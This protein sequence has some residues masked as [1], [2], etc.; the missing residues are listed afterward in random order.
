MERK[1]TFARQALE[2][3]EEARSQVGRLQRTVKML[4]SRCTGMVRNHDNP[5]GS[6]CHS[7]HQDL[8]DALAD[9]QSLLEQKQQ[10][11]AELEQKLERWIDRIPRPRWRMVLRFHYIDAL[12]LSETALE[13]T[14]AT[15]RE[16]TKDQVY[17][18]H[19]NALEA[20]DQIWP[21][22]KH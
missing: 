9:Q 12:P 3:L 7:T 4:R 8:W 18:F 11:L 14:R 20:A 17:R 1:Q 6:T 21:T 5:G 22:L 10:Q 2:A 15:G 19:R 16:F 13:L